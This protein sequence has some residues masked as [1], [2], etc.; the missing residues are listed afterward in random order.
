M[1]LYAPTPALEKPTQKDDRVFTGAVVP[2]FYVDPETRVLGCYVRPAYEVLEEMRLEEERLVAELEAKML[3]GPEKPKN[4]LADIKGLISTFK[5]DPIFPT[6]DWGDLERRTLATMQRSTYTR[7][8]KADQIIIDSLHT[9]SASPSGRLPSKSMIFD[10]MIGRM[11][12][13]PMRPPEPPTCFVVKKN[14]DDSTR[15]P[16]VSY[17][18]QFYDPTTGKEPQRE[19]CPAPAITST[20]P[21]STSSTTSSSRRA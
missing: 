7:G 10:Q 13:T 5:S 16:R 15:L 9:Y 4:I 17:I 12:R 11:S 19:P 2:D 8:V 3:A 6:V 21:P 1:E 14:R 20:S 18:E